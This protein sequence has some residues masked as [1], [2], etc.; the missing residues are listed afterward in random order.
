[1]STSKRRSRHQTCIR[2]HFPHINTKTGAKKG[3]SALTAPEA[4]GL[5]NKFFILAAKNDS[6]GGWKHAFLKYTKYTKYTGGT[7]LWSVR[8]PC[9]A[10]NRFWQINDDAIPSRQLTPSQHSPQNHFHP[11]PQA[12]NQFTPN[13]LICA[14]LQQ[15]GLLSRQT[16]QTR[17]ERLNKAKALNPFPGPSSEPKTQAADES[18]R[19]TPWV[20]QFQ[21]Q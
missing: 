12:R 9:Y 2:E 5:S 21:R 19:Q 8:S 7:A 17:H 4:G 15:R 6:R 16:S 14:C 10:W 13:T 3:H 1:M 18:R 11:S 20:H